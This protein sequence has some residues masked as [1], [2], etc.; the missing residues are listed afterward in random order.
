MP[1]V[2][3]DR[4]YRFHFYSIEGDPREPVHVHVA[5][6]GGGDAKLWLYPDVTFTYHEGL[7]PRERRW[8]L[9]Q[10]RLRREE[11]VSPWHEHFGTRDGR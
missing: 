7:D 5:R 1:V 8:I 4:G 10:V 2:F 9:R 11:I 6:R 3:L